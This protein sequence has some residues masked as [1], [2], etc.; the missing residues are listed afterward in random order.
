[1]QGKFTV[2]KI[3]IEKASSIDLRHLAIQ[4]ET[5]AFNQLQTNAPFSY[6]LKTSED[7]WFSDIF[8]GFKKAT[9][10]SNWLRRFS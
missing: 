6:P 9:L 2:K 3:S 5:N 10:V 7:L 1:M 4:V 8:R